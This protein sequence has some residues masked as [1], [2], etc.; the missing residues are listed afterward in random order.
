VPIQ[1]RLV[2]FTLG[3]GVTRQ[4]CTGTTDEA[5]TARC[6]FIVTGQ[7]LNDAATVPVTTTFVGDP[8]YL[9]SSDS[10][11]LKLQYATGRAAGLAAQIRLPLISVGLAPTPDT[12]P[13]RTA[14]ATST[15]TPCTANVSAVVVT[16]HAVCVN[17]TTAVNPGTST[18]TTTAADTRIGLPGMPVVELSGIRATSTTTCAAATGTVELTLTVAGQPITVPTGPNAA[19]DLGAH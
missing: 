17:V 1:G 7:P 3:T 12:G 14:D 16:A 5:G 6:E 2:T 13:V 11:T 4:Q 10:A 9:P 15:T 8:Y 19:I 18:A